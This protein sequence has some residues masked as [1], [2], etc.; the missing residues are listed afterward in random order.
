[1]SATP[2]ATRA[3]ALATSAALLSGCGFQGARSI[4]L[5]GGQGTGGDAYQV[6][7]EFEDVLDLV[8]Q[9]SV[10]VDNVAVAFW[11]RGGRLRRGL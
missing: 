6:T 2:R 8:P 5:P 7:V 1:M 4:P 11:L 10:K 9:S 3:L